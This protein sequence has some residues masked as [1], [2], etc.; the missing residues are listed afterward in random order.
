MK[1]VEF[2]DR[3]ATRY[4]RFYSGPAVEA[5]DRVGDDL[6]EGLYRLCVGADRA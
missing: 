3:F 1:P 6:A 2:Y 5:E 4:D